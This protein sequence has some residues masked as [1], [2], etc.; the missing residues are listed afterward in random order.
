MPK[1]HLRLRKTSCLLK[2]RSSAMSEGSNRALSKASA[3]WLPV[4]PW[5]FMT[6][7]LSIRG[8]PL[9]IEA[10]NQ[11]CGSGKGSTLLSDLLCLTFCYLAARWA[12]SFGVGQDFSTSITFLPFDFLFR[13]GS[14][15]SGLSGK[16]GLGG[17]GGSL[18]GIGGSLLWK[19]EGGLF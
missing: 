6:E 18:D 1:Y 17:G 3:I 14:E 15:G 19:G 11:A 7:A 5:K 10:E 4:P 12:F 13:L 2:D 9:S 16:V 8:A